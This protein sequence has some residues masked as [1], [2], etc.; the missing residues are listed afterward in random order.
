VL[1]GLDARDII[2]PPESN[3]RRRIRVKRTKMGWPRPFQ[4]LNSR[5][6]RLAG[7]AAVAVT[8]AIAIGYA[9]LPLAIEALTAT[10][11]MLLNIGV[12]LTAMAGGGAD[13]SAIFLAILREIVRTLTSTNALGIIAALIL[14]S[15]GALYGLQRLLGLEEESNVN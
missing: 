10:L 8:L 14:L 3:I 12:W 6:A 11:D 5:F 7:A 15:A 13:R 4:A 9:L 2:A 1:L